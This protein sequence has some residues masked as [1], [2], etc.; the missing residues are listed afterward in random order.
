M[1][2]VARYLLAGQTRSRGVI[3]PLAVLVGG[4]IV[5]YAQP[6]NPVLSTAG[7]VAAFL[8]PVQC[9]LTL[10][11]YNAQGAVDRQLL[12]A[13]VGGRRLAGGR[14]LAAGVLAAA[15]S[16][17]ALLVP[18]IGGAFER[19]PRLDEIALILGANLSATL[20]GAALA[21]PFSAPIVRNAALSTLG[22]ATCVVL[23]IALRIPPMIPIARALDTTRAGHA[24]GPL[25]REAAILLAA[26]LV[27]TAVG[28][29][30]W[31]WRE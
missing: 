18:L 5:L 31:R 4:V 15:S 12:A 28:V 24:A 9:W 8:F 1:I 20:A 30:L 22:L 6:P 13:T 17:L 3:A 26:T 29:P 7:T 14:L 23:T 16:L 27:I 10:A 11:F 19:S 21:M 25:A 2:N